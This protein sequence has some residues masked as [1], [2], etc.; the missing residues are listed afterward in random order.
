MAKRS[1]YYIKGP[2]EV[3]FWHK[4][5]RRGPDDCWPWL[6]SNINGYGIIND[7]VSKCRRA[8]H[9][10]LALDGRP[11][12]ERL[13]ALHSCDNPICV[14]PKHLRWGTDK[15]NKADAVAKGRQRGLPGELHHQARLSANDIFAIRASDETGAALG[16][17]YAV[18]KEQIYRIRLRQSWKHI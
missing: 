13:D 12:P 18:S 17:V 5:D 4:V 10:S 6:A 2:L 16:R 7:G 3:R 14:N 1:I 11:R 9:V 15:D 8:T